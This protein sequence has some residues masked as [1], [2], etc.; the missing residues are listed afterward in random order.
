MRKMPRSKSERN[1]S[2]S[3]E[4]AELLEFVQRLR[5]LMSEFDTFAH[6]LSAE[7]SWLG[8]E[9]QASKEA[10]RTR[11]REAADS[12]FQLLHLVERSSKYKELYRRPK[13]RPER[14]ERPDVER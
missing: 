1:K 2:L 12:L 13:E 11:V 8:A 7:F 9:I 4:R 3:I 14:P 5:Q 10:T 6:T